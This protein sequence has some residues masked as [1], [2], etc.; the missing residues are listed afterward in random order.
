MFFIKKKKKTNKSVNYH[1]PSLS[2]TIHLIDYVAADKMMEEFKK[3]FTSAEWLKEAKKYI[4]IYRRKNY[5]LYGGHN[6]IEVVFQNGFTDKL[7]LNVFYNHTVDGAFNIQITRDYKDLDEEF[8][9]APMIF[10]DDITEVSTCLS[11]TI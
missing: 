3:Y 11:P 4:K 9:N 5:E 7:K 10:M 6:V 2:M 1:K 8:D